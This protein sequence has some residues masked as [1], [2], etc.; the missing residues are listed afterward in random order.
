MILDKIICR[1]CKKIFCKCH[2]CITCKRL[3]TNPIIICGYC[4]QNILECNN[5]KYKK[6]I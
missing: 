3:T 4:F 6:H 5:C 2:T 1:K